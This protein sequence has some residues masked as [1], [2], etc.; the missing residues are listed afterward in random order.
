M[1]K[2]SA[3]NTGDAGSVPGLGRYP[4]S[5][6]NNMKCCTWVQSQRWQND[7]SSF[8]RQTIQHHRNPSLCRK[9][10]LKLTVLWRPIGPSKTNTKNDIL[11]IIGVVA[12]QLLSGVWLFA[13]PWTAA[14]QASLSLTISWS[15]L[16]LMSIESVMASKHLIL[17]QSLLLLSSIF[18]SIGSF[19]MNQFFASGGQSSQH[20]KKERHHSANK[21]PYSQSY[22]FSSS[23]A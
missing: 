14:H 12:V 1:V 23:H 7:L 19:P 4:H 18:P 10:Q 9:L 20:I 15:L 16:K 11:F 13:T 17:C 5:H 2:E 6:G 21:G 22:A 3:C 8:P